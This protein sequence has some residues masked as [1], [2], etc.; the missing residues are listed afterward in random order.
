MSYI[1]TKKV[2]GIEYFY[3][4]EIRRVDGKRKPCYVSY[5]GRKDSFSPP[6]LPPGLVMPDKVLAQVYIMESRHRRGLP[7]ENIF[8]G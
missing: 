1:V 6:E 7:C 5:M 3:E 2:K 4:Y 8:M